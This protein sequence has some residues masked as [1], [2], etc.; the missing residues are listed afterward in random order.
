MRKKWL[1]LALVFSVVVNVAA[2]GTIGLHWWKV[3]KVQHLHRP[4]LG[5]M[6]NMLSLSP[7]QMQELDA[8]SGQISEE[9]RK[10][11]Q[12]IFKTRTRLMQL[13]RAP[14][15]DSTA[16]DEVLQK[17]ASSQ[18]ALERKVIQNIL[19]M[20]QV[21]TPEQREKLFRMV[22]RRGRWDKMGPGLEHKMRR[23]PSGPGGPFGP[24]EK[25]KRD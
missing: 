9:I 10:I 6:R 5:P 11:R 16:I 19:Q 20:R 18:V 14:D 21:L 4:I 23:G 2:I 24:H 1:I 25:I 7:A 17:M 8:Q 12:D 3:R 13:L 15:P 22:E